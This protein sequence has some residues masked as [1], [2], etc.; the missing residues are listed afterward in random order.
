MHSSIHHVIAYGQS[1]STGW[2]GWPALSTMPR[3]HSLMLGHSVRPQS[4]GT[5]NWQPVGDGELHPL[6]ATVQ[7][8]N[9]GEV[10]TP[11]QI[12]ALQP[13]ALALGETVLEAAV[14]TWCGRMPAANAHLVLASACGSGGCTLEQLSKGADPELFNRLRECAIA[15]KRA[16]AAVGR[17]YS[18]AAL[19]FLQGESNNWALNGGTADRVAYKALLHQFFRDFTADIAEGIAAQQNRPIMLTYQTGGAYASAT[20]SVPQAQL[21]LALEMPDWFLVAPVYPLMDK[22]TGHLDANSYRWLGAQFGKVMHRVLT[23]GEDWKPLHPLRAIVD[24][25]SVLIEFHVPVPPL[26]WGRPY[27]GLS[28]LDVADRG[29]TVLD[30]AGPVSITAVELAGPSGVRITLERP[31]GADA[32]LRYADQRHLGRGCLHDSDPDV[33]LNCFECDSTKGQ[34]SDTIFAALAGRPYPLMNW[35][36]AFSIELS[37]VIRNS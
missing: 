27:C 33:A 9:T 30:E 20:Q 7:D 13:G 32:V 17:D 26:A 3:H 23:L 24:R 29:F 14:N 2:E 37:S 21:E 5:P 15:S 6:T 18:V 10:L 35:C 4:E 31:P 28:A 22:P 8:I 19:L 36:V 11:E 1:L 25:S 12:A 16:A 34:G